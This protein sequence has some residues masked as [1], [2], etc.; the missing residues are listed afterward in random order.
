MCCVR[1]E[2]GVGGWYCS[3]HWSQGGDGGHVCLS[4]ALARE[5]P[6]EGA[7]VAA[8][9][10][11]AGPAPAA[12]PLAPAAGEEG[13]ARARHGGGCCFQGTPGPGPSSPRCAARSPALLGVGTPCRRVLRRCVLRQDSVA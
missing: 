1:G 7:L 10:G 3:G 8:A 12:P 11:V 2:V 5:G 4:A 9:G 13:T 6:R